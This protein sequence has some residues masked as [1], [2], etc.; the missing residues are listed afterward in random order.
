MGFKKRSSGE[1]ELSQLGALLYQ[2]GDG[3][4]QAARALL[5]RFAASSCSVGE[6]LDMAAVAAGRELADMGHRGGFLMNVTYGASS[7]SEL[8]ELVDEADSAVDPYHLGPPL[9]R[10][11]D[12]L[13]L[14]KGHAKSPAGDR[15]EPGGARFS[16]LH[17]SFVE[18]LRP[19]LLACIERH[20]RERAR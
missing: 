10:A 16:L 9:L 7:A 17:A 20:E 8:D 12:E 19:R 15:G 11:L 13:L 6:F 18:A 14:G 2:L 4:E 3:S 1:S 5:E